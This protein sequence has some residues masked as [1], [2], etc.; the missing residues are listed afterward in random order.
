MLKLPQSTQVQKTLPK[1]AIYA[2]FSMDSATR[3]RFDADISRISII[4]E[5]STTTTTLASGAKIDSFFILHVI[6]KREDYDEKSLII[7]SKL[8]PQKLLLLLQFG[9]KYRLSTFHNKL[10]QSSWFLEGEDSLE[11]KGLDLDS[12]WEAILLKIGEITIEQGRSL[13]EQMQVDENR[14]KIEKEIEALQKRKCNEKQFNKQMEISGEIRRLR[15]MIN[16][17]EI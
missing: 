14:K 13:E 15:E 4:N 17:G 1:K 16:S 8:I 5:I 3:E 12:A 2:K 9:E 7:L 10:L 6:L 11:L